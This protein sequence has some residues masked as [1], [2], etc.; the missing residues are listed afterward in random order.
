[1]VRVGVMG[2]F[3]PRRYSVPGVGVGVGVGV[4]VGVRG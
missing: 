2:A 3:G 4:R 1:V